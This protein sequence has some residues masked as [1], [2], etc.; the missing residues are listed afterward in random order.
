MTT[1]RIGGQKAAVG[2]LAQ[3]FQSLR[4]E[5]KGF[6]A[7]LSFD[8]RASTADI[9][10]VT[11]ET[12]A[13]SRTMSG[14]LRRAFDQAIF[15]GGKLSD[16][17]RNLATSMSRS[18][19]NSALGPVQ[20]AV[21]SGI[22]S[23]ITGGIGSLFGFAKGG[24]FSSGRVQAF[25]KGGVISGPTTFPMRGGTGL[26]GEAGPEAIMPLTRGADG[27]LGVKAAGGAGGGVNVTINIATKDADS[28]RRSQSQ[29]S[30]AI[31]RAV[32]RGQRNL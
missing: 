14:G 26:M 1:D 2:D 18:V 25:A 30:A 9:Q 32:S 31:A 24:A 23:A 7:D 17:F 10:R 11:R 15:G 19:L 28:F 3:A 20:Q 16:V 22:S 27:S 6:A 21:G 4:S 29:V 12:Q 5:S 13:L 8:L